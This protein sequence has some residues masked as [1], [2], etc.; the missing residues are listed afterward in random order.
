MSAHPAF[1]PENALGQLARWAAGIRLEPRLNARGIVFSPVA[2]V[3]RELPP[4]E[5]LFLGV[6]RPAD[7]LRRAPRQAIT[8][9]WPGL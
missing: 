1:N 2:L 8:R 5:K 7:A 9:R 3:Y 6:A 4:R